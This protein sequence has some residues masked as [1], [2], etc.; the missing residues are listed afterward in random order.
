MGWTPISSRLN[1]QLI[2][3][4]LKINTLEE[5]RLSRLVTKWSMRV[6][7]NYQLKNWCWQ[8]R[9][10]LISIHL[11]EF[12]S[13]KPS[14]I[15]IKECILLVKNKLH[16]VAH[17]NWLEQLHR[18]L[19]ST[20]ESGGK[21]KIYKMIMLEPSP[22]HYVLSLLD[23]GPRWV[24]ASLR[25]GCLPLGIETGRYRTP[26]VPLEQRV[27]SVC[28]SGDVEDEF[29]FV[30]ICCKLNHIRHKMLTDITLV[31]HT[32]QFIS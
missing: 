26:K 11:S 10:I 13:T 22:P 12:Y 5:N 27:C 32:F 29:H 14:N 18:P 4:W 1:C 7:E 24:M 17:I 15:S 6:A 8:V 2:S 19:D 3:W 28:N 30:M 21:L 20:S 16:E 9:K 25:A 23:P 31:D